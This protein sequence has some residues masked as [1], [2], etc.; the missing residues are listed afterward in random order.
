MKM[1]FRNL[2][3]F[4]S[5]ALM[6]SFAFAQRGGSPGSGNGNGNN[7]QG[8]NNT[9]GYNCNPTINLT[10]V[11]GKACIDVNA[12]N[13][14]AKIQPE[15]I[16]ETA[17]LSFSPS[18]WNNSDLTW[19][20]TGQD[21]IDNV[22]YD[23]YE[24]NGNSTTATVSHP[25]WGTSSCNNS[26]VNITKLVVKCNLEVSASAN[27]TT[28]YYGSITGLN[29]ASLSASST[30]AYGSVSYSWSNGASGS[31][32]TVNA[33]STAG[34][35]TYTVTATDSRGCK[36]TSSVDITTILCAL[37]ASISANRTVVFYGA[38]LG[39]NSA[40]LTASSTG[41]VGSVG[42]TWSTGSTSNPI[43]V[44]P[45]AS[46]TYTVNALDAA[47]CPASA[48]FKI[49]VYDIRCGNNL[50]KASMTR[51]TVSGGRTRCQD[52][53]VSLNGTQSLLN[54][55][56]TWG[57]CGV[58]YTCGSAPAPAAE[59]VESSEVKLAAMPNP[60]SGLTVINYTPVQDETA[61]AT[62]YTLSGQVVEVLGTREVK[63]GFDAAWTFKPA[64][65]QPATYI[66]VVKT[67]T[68]VSKSAVIIA[69]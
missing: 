46:T 5:L 51:T 33:T 4:C 28:V 67:S 43:T 39:Y 23:V 16:R 31:P 60:F 69:Q 53:C 26:K 2:L 41:A 24:S 47:G 35:T 10:I 58:S 8:N 55:G 44:T 7:G 15:S 11:D 9:L 1:N 68:G 54:N 22:I 20:L 13:I 30:G 27:R 45:T 12:T 17:N 49:C 14:R 65:S 52:Q 25:D 6:S 42:Y 48:E 64:V 32:I 18:C 38:N 50:D 36:A 3:T 21:T 19:T 40:T 29:Q 66:A 61:T 63:A 37:E 56:W 62:I 59:M 34:T 57:V